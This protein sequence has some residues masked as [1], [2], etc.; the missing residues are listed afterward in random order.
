V[1]TPSQDVIAFDR[2]VT[3]EDKRILESTN[4][5]VP[6]SLSQEQHM[7]TD[8]PGIIMRKKQLLS[9]KR[10]MRWNIPE[11]IVRAEQ[12]NSLSNLIKIVFKPMYCTNRILGIAKSSYK[13][14]FPF[15]KRE[16][17]RG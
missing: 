5:D 14:Q 1:D 15:P 17:T 4:Y 2:A 3:L 13:I 8:K 16:G 12:Q 7:F 11:I 10:I 9:L 6:L